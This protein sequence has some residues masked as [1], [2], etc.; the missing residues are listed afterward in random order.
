[1]NGQM[2][3]GIMQ[4]VGALPSFADGCM[5]NIKDLHFF[6]LTQPFTVSVKKKEGEPDRKLYP[7]PYG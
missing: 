3:K 2:Y 6:K 4:N 7:L 1:M 5:H